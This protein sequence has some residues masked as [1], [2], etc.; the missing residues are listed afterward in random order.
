MSLFALASM[1]DPGRLAARAVGCVTGRELAL[2]TSAQWLDLP[3]TR[4]HDERS[5]ELKG[6]RV[7]AVIASRQDCAMFGSG[8]VSA[9][10]RRGI[11]C[12][13]PP[14]AG[15]ACSARRPAQPLDASGF[16]DVSM[17][18]AWWPGPADRRRGAARADL[19]PQ[20]L[21]WRQAGHA[22]AE[23]PARSAPAR[24]PGRESQ[25]C[26]G[27]PSRVASRRRPSADDEAGRAVSAHDQMR[28]SP[29]QCDSSGGRWFGERRRG[30]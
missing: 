13:L 23:D 22:P 6:L 29:R 14:R 15:A 9:L 11:D 26:R 18:D 10:M 8:S 12:R 25:G 30:D 1:S 5:G 16:L 28:R 24:E 2:S 27:L 4:L 7:P 20:R 3:A 17:G 19:H 21:S